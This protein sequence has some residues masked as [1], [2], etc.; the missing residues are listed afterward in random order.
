MPA[1][2]KLRIKHPAWTCAHCY[3]QYTTRPTCVPV[4]VAVPFDDVLESRIISAVLGEGVTKRAGNA[5]TQYRFCNDSCAAQAQLPRLSETNL[6]DFAA[7]CIARHNVTVN[8]QALKTESAIQAAKAASEDKL[9][10]NWCDVFLHG[11]QKKFESIYSIAYWRDP[12]VG[13]FL[14]TIELTIAAGLYSQ[15]SFQI[16]VMSLRC[17]RAMALALRED[18]VLGQLN[19]QQLEEILGRDRIMSSCT[20]LGNK[21]ADDCKKQII[22]LLHR[23]VIIPVLFRFQ[24]L[25][26]RHFTRTR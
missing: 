16:T 22:R 26:F 18:V 5:R 23:A 15:A 13:V 14:D 17:N 2:K 12:S 7:F 11:Y 25:D 9:G 21:S 10:R 4:A 6:D 20:K 8:R 19:E 24:S 1:P 3:A